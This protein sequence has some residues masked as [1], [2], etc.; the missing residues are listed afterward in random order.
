MRRLL[1][2][3]PLLSTV[4][5]T[6]IAAVAVIVIARVT[7][8]DQIG[9]VFQDFHPG[10]ILLLAATELATYPAYVLAYR[11]VAR[12]HGHAPLSLPIVTRIVVAGFGPFS[13]GGGFAIDKRALEAIDEDERSARVRVMALGTLEWAILAPAACVTAIVLLAQGADILP[14]LLW[15][16]AL[17]VPPSFAL[18]LWASAPHRSAWLARVGGRRVDLIVQMLEGIA[19]LRALI[20][21]D[22]LRN[23]WAVVGI[24][25]YWAADMAAL[26]AA[27]RI[28]GIDLSF[29]K[30]VI[31]YST[32]YAATRRSLPLG[33]AGATEVLMTYALYWVRQ[34]LAPALAAVMAYRA[35]NFLLVAIPALIAQRQLMPML[36]DL[37]TAPPVGSA[38]AKPREPE[39]PPKV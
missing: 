25:A 27:L 18:A 13:L 15:P 28:F 12:L 24:T 14:S 1:R 8:A 32:G 31:A 39:L 3:Q 21:G 33:G 23:C 11:S 30:L 4:L 10:W 35:F 17:A 6:A 9:R 34:P 7:A 16:W 20:A 19:G 2:E 5:A 26:W 36:S 29:G 37:S 38:S 22:P